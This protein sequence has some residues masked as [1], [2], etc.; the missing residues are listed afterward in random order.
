MIAFKVTYGSVFRGPLLAKDT[1]HNEDLIATYMI[2][3]WHSEKLK[4]E[5]TKIETRSA[6]GCTWGFNPDK[7]GLKGSWCSEV[8]LLDGVPLEWYCDDR[9]D[10][11]EGTIEFDV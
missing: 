8:G 7:E 5:F 1:T 4:F 6:R 2:C 3:S 9:T 10:T 11:D